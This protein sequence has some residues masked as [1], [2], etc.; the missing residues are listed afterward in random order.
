MGPEGGGGGDAEMGIAHFPLS[1]ANV[2]KLFN[3]PILHQRF[4]PLVRLV[5][6]AI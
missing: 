3:V 4:P 6:G 2:R 5:Q 1:L